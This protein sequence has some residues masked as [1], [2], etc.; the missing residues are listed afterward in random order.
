MSHKNVLLDGFFTE[1][2]TI[3]VLTIEIELFD[4][5]HGDSSFTLPLFLY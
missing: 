1:N 2:S 3:L 5:V 4:F